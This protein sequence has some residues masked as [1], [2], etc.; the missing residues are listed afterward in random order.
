MSYTEILT[1]TTAVASSIAAVGSFEAAR[2]SL[3]TANRAARTGESAA[4]TAEAVAQIER[5]RWHAE[6][7]PKLD[8]H[9]DDQAIMTVRFAGPAALGPIRR[10]ELTIRDDSDHHGHT[11]LAGSPSQAELAA[12][13][14][15]PLRFRP[16]IDDAGEQG[17][18]AGP[19]GLDLNETRRIAMEVT[20]APRFFSGGHRT[21]LTRWVNQ[22]VRLWVVCHVD[23][24]RPWRISRD[25]TPDQDVLDTVL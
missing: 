14:W 13:V 3:K 23:G 16:G 11:G 17:R 5:A 1:V 6:L 24:H 2:R 9:I 4:A 15:S 25:V 12:V 22:P 19:F 8:I 21:W 7:Q 18:N 20:N 10:I